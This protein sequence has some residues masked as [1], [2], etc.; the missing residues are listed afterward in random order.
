MIEILDLNVRF[1]TSENPAVSHF[2][3]RIPE[4]KTACL[5]GPSGSGKSSVL[6][7]MNGLLKPESGEIRIAGARLDPTELVQQRRQIGYVMQDSALFPHW[8]VSRNIGLVPRLLKWPDDQLE[9]RVD[10]CLELVNL[11]PSRFRDRAPDDLSGGQQQRVS[12]ARAIAAKPRVLLMDEPFSALDPMNR[13]A[14]QDEF[15]NLQKSLNLTTILVSHDIREAFKMADMIIIMNA[16]EI[17]QT[18]TSAELKRSPVSDF[19]R[20]FVSSGDIS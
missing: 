9:R 2:S 18:G 19:V 6:K 5:I 13:E 20:N 11:T 1:D 14:L 8:T 17:I 12:I 16:G 15:L 7:C 10:E 3:M 4:G